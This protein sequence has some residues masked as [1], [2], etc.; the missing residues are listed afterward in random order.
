MVA[1]ASRDLRHRCHVLYLPCRQMR[2][3]HHIPARAEHHVGIEGIGNHIAVFDDAD[4][5]PLSL[6]IIGRRLDDDRVLSAGRAFEGARP[7][8]AFR[9]ILGR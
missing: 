6:Q 8:S 2:F 9:P 3:R 7:W 1:T 4:G 5:M